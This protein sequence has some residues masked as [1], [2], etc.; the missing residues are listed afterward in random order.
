MTAMLDPGD[1][2]PEEV[3]VAGDWHR[4]P[5]WSRSVVARC[6]D[7]LPRESPRI[8]LHAGDLGVYADGDGQH[9]LDVLN[10]SLE[11]YD[12]NLWFVD[13][14]HEDFA[15]L[16]DLA[17]THDPTGPVLIRSRIIW[18]PRGFRWT[19]HGRTWLA[20]GGA[21][22][23]N[24]VDLTLFLD[25]FPDEEITESQT[26]RVMA[27]GPADVM[28]CHDAPALVPMRLSPGGWPKEDLWRSDQHRKRLQAIVDV[29]KPSYLLH[30]H[31]HLS[32]YTV[33][34]MPHGPVT[35]TGLDKNNAKTGNY[36]VLDVQLMG[37]WAR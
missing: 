15:F 20:L 11:R 8:I 32:H 28:L 4:D 34:D 2:Q 37:Y 16:H 24:R 5:T 35:V 30:G 22:S 21:V 1:Y 19:W 12:A 7:L 26:R 13:G 6:P 10:K 33:V 18:L 17:G 27:D 31:Y 25:W 29:V 3:L 14:N 9:F 23:L 36:R